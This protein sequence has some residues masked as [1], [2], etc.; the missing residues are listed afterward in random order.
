MPHASRSFHR[1]NR[2]T[3]VDGNRVVSPI[4]PD[5]ATCYNWRSRFDDTIRGAIST[6][7]CPR[8]L[9]RLSHLAGHH[10]GP[11]S[12]D[13]ESTVGSA[14]RRGCNSRC[15]S[16]CFCRESPAEF[17]SADCGA[18]YWEVR[19]STTTAASIAARS[20]ERERKETACG[21]RRPETKMLPRVRQGVLLPDRNP[22]SVLDVES[23]GR[24]AC[25]SEG[26]GRSGRNESRSTLLAQALAFA[27]TH[28]SD[29]RHFRSTRRIA[30]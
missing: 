21:S 18:S 3:T 29:T 7:N 30:L 28:V 2:E 22:P 24:T 1:S 13:S 20:V 19:S 12:L 11:L 27:L 10:S 16:V 5:S 26:G 8:L 4:V 17:C 15:E 14:R 25:S 9:S 6:G 23:R